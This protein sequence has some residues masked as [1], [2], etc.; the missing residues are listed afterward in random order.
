[1][2]ERIYLLQTQLSLDKINSYR[3]YQIQNTQ[4]TNSI[5]TK[6]YSKYIH[7]CIANRHTEDKNREN[8]KAKNALERSVTNVTMGFNSGLGAPNLTRI[9]SSSYKTYRVNKR[10]FKYIY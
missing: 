3:R 4:L 8:M 6:K 10:T 5:F 2:Q 9:P 1:M 7:V